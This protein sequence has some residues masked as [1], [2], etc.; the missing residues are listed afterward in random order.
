MELERNKRQT[1]S[2]ACWI[3]EDEENLRFTQSIVYAIIEEEEL[4]S[5]N[6]RKWADLQIIENG[7]RVLRKKFVDASSLKNA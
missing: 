2:G 6:Y 5:I 3:E 7:R 1:E 4:R